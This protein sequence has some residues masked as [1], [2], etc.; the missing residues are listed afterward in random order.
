MK[1]HF[2]FLSTKMGLLS[3]STD[4]KVKELLVYLQAA[5]FY[6]SRQTPIPAKYLAGFEEV[7]R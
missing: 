6:F 4:R 5:L 2:S 1:A 3:V 7:L